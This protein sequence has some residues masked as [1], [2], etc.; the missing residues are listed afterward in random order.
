VEILL[1]MGRMSV[2][3][4]YHRWAKITPANIQEEGDEQE[5]IVLYSF[6]EK[7]S[8]R[9]YTNMKDLNLRDNT[10]TT[11]YTAK[12]SKSLRKAHTI[13]AIVQ[14]YEGKVILYQVSEGNQIKIKENH[15]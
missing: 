1:F 10:Q 13:A 5:Y 7:P 15:V 4:K 14:H 2:A 8:P 6:D 12:V 9:F 3:E 11:T